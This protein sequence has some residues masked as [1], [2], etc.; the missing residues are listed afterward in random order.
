MSYETI[1][2][3]VHEGV[4]SITLNRPQSLNAFND[5][6]IAETTDAFKQAGRRAD[7]R[8]VVITGSGRGFSAGQDLKDVMQ[9][10]AG[11]SIG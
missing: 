10:G 8:C 9:R 4:A 7:I 6:M 3:D 5:Q 11:I 2:F 1:L